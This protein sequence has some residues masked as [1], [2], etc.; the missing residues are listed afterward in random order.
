MRP[1]WR[2]GTCGHSC[3]SLR[4]RVV[5]ACILV[6]NLLEGHLG[7]I[8]NFAAVLC[9]SL[10]RELT[11]CSAQSL[12]VFISAR[13]RY[14]SFCLSSSCNGRTVCGDAVCLPLEALS[15]AIGAVRACGVL[16]LRTTHS[17][18]DLAQHFGYPLRTGATGCG[19]CDSSLLTHAWAASPRKS[20]LAFVC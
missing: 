17:G 10:C 15:P 11:V 4:P 2:A 19:A 12:L 18:D 5:K 7:P 16:S 3:L 14:R 13:C 8:R 6:G 1:L 20:G 9:R